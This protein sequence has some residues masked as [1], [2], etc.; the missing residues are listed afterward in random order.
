MLF[1]HVRDL[2][3]GKPPKIGA[4]KPNS[5]VMLKDKTAQLNHLKKH[6]AELLNA[7]WIVIKHKPKAFMQQS[8]CMVQTEPDPPLAGEIQN[9]LWR[10]KHNKA[11][12]TCAMTLKLL[13][14][15]GQI[16]LLWM[17]M[18]F[19]T[20]RQLNW[21]LKI[22]GLDNLPSMEKQL[23]AN[24]RETQLSSSFQLPAI[25]LAIALLN[26]DSL[27]ACSLFNT[28]FKCWLLLSKS[29]SVRWILQDK[30]AQ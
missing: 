7:E 1:K 14:F 26:S 9:A 21:F 10:V 5:G 22:E 13:K 30:G 19:P 3:D 25:F 2:G 20:F 17:H 16:M 29:I 4:I 6:F 15:G 24:D 28:D 27:L 23:I 12:G 18:L 8:T 11:Q